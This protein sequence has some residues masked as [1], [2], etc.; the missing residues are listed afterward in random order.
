MIEFT[1]SRV[2][3]GFCGLIILAS[4]L[5]PLSAVYDSKEDVDLQSQCDNI[6]DI[7]D[8][9]GNSGMWHMELQGTDIIPEGCTLTFYDRTVTLT[10][11][12]REYH[13]L[14]SYRIY[15]SETFT[16]DD[17]LLFMNDDVSVSVM[18]TE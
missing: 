13:S 18:K 6:S 10:C 3:M 11:G 5:Y 14:I 1:L 17:I 8:A 9:F 15:S 16:A 12:D 7:A 4:L 2:V